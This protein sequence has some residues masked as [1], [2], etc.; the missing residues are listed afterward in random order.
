MKKILVILLMIGASCFA[1][2]LFALDSIKV[3]CATSKSQAVKNVDLVKSIQIDVTIAKVYIHHKDALMYSWGEG[4]DNKIPGI[5][6]GYKQNM[7]LA[8]ATLAVVCYPRGVIGCDA[9]I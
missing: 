4:I 7:N 1:S 3:G 2:P 8:L 6:G 9:L 5:G